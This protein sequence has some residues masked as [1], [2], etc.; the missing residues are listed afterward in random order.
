[1][2]TNAGAHPPHSTIVSTNELQPHFDIIKK[3]FQL[4]TDCISIT[5]ASGFTEP[6][7]LCDYL[8]TLSGFSH[9]GENNVTLM[10]SNLLELSDAEHVWDVI[11]HLARQYCSFLNCNVFEMIEQN[12]KGCLN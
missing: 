6:R 2:V 7:D 9:S 8:L 4:Y 11:R 1:M 3:Q 5:I 12:G 10:S